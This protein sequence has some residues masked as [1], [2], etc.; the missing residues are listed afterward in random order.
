MSPKSIAKN[1]EETKSFLI[2]LARL[3]GC[4]VIADQLT[5][6]CFLAANPTQYANIAALL[7]RF[8]VNS[9]KGVLKTVA[10]VRSCAGEKAHLNREFDLPYPFAVVKEITQRY[11]NANLFR[12]DL[13]SFYE[14]KPYAIVVCKIV[15]REPEETLESAFLHICPF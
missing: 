8:R 4:N 13:F 1:V 6:A 14:F 3:L 9:R 12:T 2:P 7:K 15:Q 10:L 5:D 11:N